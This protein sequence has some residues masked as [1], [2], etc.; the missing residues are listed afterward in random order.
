MLEKASEA[1]RRINDPAPLKP[2]G[3]F[4]TLVATRGRAGMN[5]GGIGRHSGQQQSGKIYSS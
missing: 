2:P 3:I 5:A 1:V 4:R